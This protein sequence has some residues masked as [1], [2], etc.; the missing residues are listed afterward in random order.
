MDTDRPGEYHFMPRLETLKT[1]LVNNDYTTVNQELKRLNELPLDKNI[2]E[3]L[4]NIEKDIL[5]FEYEKA[6]ARLS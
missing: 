4:E 5:L 1:A 6:A 3:L 2:R